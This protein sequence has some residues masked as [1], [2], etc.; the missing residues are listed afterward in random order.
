MT[1][2]STLAG[3]EEFDFGTVAVRQ[4]AGFSDTDGVTFDSTDTNVNS[5]ADADQVTAEAFGEISQTPHL[6]KIGVRSLLMFV[7][8]SCPPSNFC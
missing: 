3:F 7:T 2:P 4:G 5:F 8:V 6:M 1:T